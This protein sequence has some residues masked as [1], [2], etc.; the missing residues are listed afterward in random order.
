MSLTESRLTRTS[1]STGTEGRTHLTATAVTSSG[2]GRSL[3]R[4]VVWWT[5]VW[6]AVSAA[7]STAAAWSART[8]RPA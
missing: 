1:A 5:G 6:G 8:V 2:R 7:I 3:V 4:A